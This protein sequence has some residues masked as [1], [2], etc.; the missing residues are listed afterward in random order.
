MSTDTQAPEITEESS[1]QPREVPA[2]AFPLDAL[3]EMTLEPLRSAQSEEEDAQPLYPWERTEIPQKSFHDLQWPQL[4]EHL[5]NA[6]VSPEGRMLALSLR[7][8]QKREAVERRMQ[9]ISECQQ[10]LRIDDAPPLRG[11][12]DIRKAIAYATRGGVLIGED[13]YAVARN[14]DVA[15]RASRYFRQRKVNAPY[16]GEAAW[17]L[18]ACD[19]LRHALNHA[20]EP[21]GRLADAASPDLGRLR[22]AVQNHHD[23]IRAKVDHLLKASSMATHLQDDFFTVREDRYVL[24]IRVSSKNTVNGIVHGYSSSGQTAFIEPDELITLNNQLRWSQIELREEEERI[25]AKL[26]GMVARYSDPLLRTM[27]ILA[28]LDLIMASATLSNQLGSN[29]PELTDG[30]L[31]LKRAR[32]PLLWLKFARTIAGEEVNDTVPN[33]VRLDEEKN[34][35]VVSGPNTGGKTVLLKT[36][37][38]C[39]LMVRCG[40]PIPVAQGSKIPL[41]RGIYTDIGDEQSI[42]R[43]LSTFS[44]H[45]TNINTFVNKTDHASLVLLDE[46]F[47]GTDPLQGAALAV[48]LLEELTT[49]G[50][51]T[52]V[53]THLESLKTLAFQSGAYANASMGFDLEKL[54]PTYTVIYGLPG[55]SYALRIAARLGFPEQIIGRAKGVLEGEEHQS[56]EEILS[57]LEDK[58]V[59]ME[60]EMRRLEHARREAEAN[61]NKYHKRYNKLVAR[62]KDMVHDQT[63]K[64][65]EELDAAR[66]LIREKIAGLQKANSKKT[67]TY[68]QTELEKMRDGLSGIDSKIQ[69]AKDYTKPPK[70]GPKG[71]V[72]IKS[73]DV[74]EGMDVYAHSFKRK[75]TLIGFDKSSHEAHVQMGVLKIKMKLADLYYPDEASRRKHQSGGGQRSGSNKQ[76]SKSSGAGERMLLPQTSDNTVDL[77]GMRADEAL[78]KVEL[79]LDA[80]YAANLGGAYIIHGHG[81]G[82][83]KRAVRGYLPSSSYVT[84][85]RRGE[86]SEGGDGV[87]VAFV[88]SN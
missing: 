59:E 26:S 52:V 33:D 65:K 81:T 75:G 36:L 86:R 61:K 47:A 48:A 57:S 3:M 66:N 82:A 84:D 87:T 45:L 56:V 13:L 41:F 67:K 21:G 60:S 19:E 7:P 16:L 5:S 39:G 72:Q 79:F 70:T 10:L 40:L 77:R 88:R 55:S 6:A 32:H 2:D 28:Y 4:A 17:A 43:D 24:P 25:L 53:T 83:L 50:A 31:S 23:R 44:G 54:T 76:A 22:R 68:S 8:L 37:G 30:A 1:E 29:V 20:V 51:T 34:V 80:I 58:R 62:E 15:A 18:D 64:L 38:L 14:C 46:L 35:L 74:K 11:L 78:E 42:E 73:E 85:F 27:D 71:L 12:S 9:E 49:R 69:K 63:R